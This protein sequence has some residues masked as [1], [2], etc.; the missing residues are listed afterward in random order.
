MTKLRDVTLCLLVRD[1]QVLLAMKKRG[2]GEGKWNGLGGKVSE[3]E[4]IKEAAIR[5]TQEECGVTPT[6]LKEVG[7]INFTF[8]D[9]SAHNDVVRAASRS[10]KLSTSQPSTLQSEFVHDKHDWDQTMTIFLVEDWE[11]EPEESEE[12][13]PQWFDIDKI[14]FEN[15]W[16]GD[17]KWM[18][19]VLKGEYIN[20]DM[21]FDISGKMLSYKLLGSQ[22]EKD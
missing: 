7:K 21:V 10:Q 13:K 14:P 11:G 5:E 3:G 8:V 15:M 6:S 1:N 16:D 22:T 9:E 4:T 20:A 2:F 12:M 17:E 18:P 19:Q